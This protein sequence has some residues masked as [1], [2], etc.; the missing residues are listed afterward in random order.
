[1][2]GPRLHIRDYGYDRFV[3]RGLLRSFDSAM[4]HAARIAVAGEAM[5]SAYESRY[6]K[7]GAILRQGLTYRPADTL[8]PLTSNS[9]LRIGFAGSLTARDAFD[10]LLLELG[11]RQWT[12]AGR[13]VILRIVGAHL[14]LLPMGP[15]HIE[16]FGWQ[17]VPDMIRLMQECD[18]LYMP[19]PFTPELQ[20]FTELSFPN[21]LCTYVP[22]RRP[23]LLHTPPNASL[24]AFFHRFP[25]GPQ[26]TTLNARD[27]VHQLEQA[28]MNPR[29]YH[30]YT[31]AAENAFKEELNEE[32]L[33]SE[34]RRFLAKTD[35]TLAA[36]CS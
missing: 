6:G 10:E 29:V 22:A 28:V 19:Q 18:F 26:T 3:A 20:E 11:R 24:P 32:R 7:K 15:Q 30:D 33:R 36:V 12:I 16:Y 2:D 1:M 21:K 23:I 5:Q 17:A 27:L 8:K 25:C 13:K 14:K 9:I 35:R 34:V 4:E 31:Q